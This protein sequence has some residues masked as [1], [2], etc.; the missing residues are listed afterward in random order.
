MTPVGIS[1]IPREPR[2]SGSLTDRQECKAVG[3]SG[4]HFSA[5]PSP[6]KIP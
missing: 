1:E 5:L 2:G 3:T 4:K 6:Q